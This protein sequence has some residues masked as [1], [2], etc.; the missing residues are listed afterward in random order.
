[1]RAEAWASQYV[2]LDILK[3]SGVKMRTRAWYWIGDLLVFT[4]HGSQTRS[5]GCG[6]YG[7]RRV[8]VVWSMSSPVSI[9]AA[10]WP[11]LI[12]AAAPE[13]RLHQPAGF[14]PCPRKIYHGTLS[15][16]YF[17]LVTSYS[18]VV[19][20][21]NLYSSMYSVAPIPVIQRP[22]TLVRVQLSP[23]FKPAYKHATPKHSIPE[24]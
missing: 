22:A 11:C 3:S 10:S 8:A 9:Q 1:M 14:Y 19:K 13:L 12:S 5:I 20:F 4:R 2:W 16:R 23:L 6:L 7:N 21:R 24:P 18:S 15:I 17:S